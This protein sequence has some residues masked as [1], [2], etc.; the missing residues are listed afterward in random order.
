MRSFRLILVL[1]FVASSFAFV[2]QPVGV[3]QQLAIDT[4]G[5]ALEIAQAIAADPSTVVGA[6]FLELPPS[7]TPTAVATGFLAGFP[8]DGADYGILTS[9]DANLADDA[10]TSGSSG[11]ANGGNPVRGNTDYDVTVLRIDLDVP[12]GVNCL[13]GIEFRFLSDEYPE[14]VGTAFNDAFILEL[15]ATSWTTS[16]S[17][18]SAP[19]NFAFDPTGSV[20]SINAAGGTSMTAAAAEGT[21]Y[22][23]ATPVLTAATP[24]TPGMHS[25]YISIFDQGDQIYDSAVFLDNLR[26]GTVADVATE[27][28]PGAQVVD[29]QRPLPLLGAHGITGTRDNMEPNLRFAESVV[30]GLPGWRSADLQEVG[31]VWENGIKLFNNAVALAA[32]HDSGAV[33]VIAHSKG[34]LDARVAMSASPTIFEDLAMLATP[35]GG[36][37]LAD[38]LCRLRRLEID[39]VVAEMGPCDNAGDGLYNLQTGYIADVFNVIVKDSPQHDFWIAAGD[40]IGAAFTRE[41]RISCNA[42]ALLGHTCTDVDGP[43][44]LGDSDGENAVCVWSAFAQVAGFDPGGSHVAIKPV[45]EGLNHTDMRQDA[46][47]NTAVLAWMYGPFYPDNPWVIGDG[48]ACENMSRLDDDF[49]AATSAMVPVVFSSTQ[50]VNAV[51]NFGPVQLQHLMAVE[52]GP[53]GT[54]VVSVSDEDA[55]FGVVALGGP[56]DVSGLEVRDAAGGVVDPLGVQ[57]VDVFD[58]RGSLAALYP[59]VGSNAELTVTGDAGAVIGL[60]FAVVSEVSA[61]ADAVPQ[62]DGTVQLVV[63]VHGASPS[64]ANKLEVVAFVGNGPHGDPVALPLDRVSGDQLIYRASITPELGSYQPV[65]I[66]ISG[67]HTRLV[68]TGFIL[69]DGTGS[70]EALEYDALVDTDGDNYPDVLELGIRVSSDVAGLHTLSLQLK[71]GD[72]VAGNG[73]ATAQLAVGTNTMVVQIDLVEMAAVGLAGPYE[74]TDLVLTR[75]LEMAWVARADSLGL[76]S[77]LPLEALGSGILRISRPTAE[78]SDRDRDGRFD[79][80][81]WSWTTWAPQAGTYEFEAALFGPQG[82]QIGTVSLIEELTEGP[83]QLTFAFDGAVVGDHLAGRYGLVDLTGVLS[84]DRQ[85]FARAPAGISAIFDPARWIAGTPDISTLIGLWRD[86]FNKGE[87]FVNGLYR[88]QLNRLLRVERAIEAGNTTR[89]VR[90]LGRFIDHVTRHSGRL[91]TPEAA[92]QVSGYASVLKYDLVE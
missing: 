52:L 82:E 91:I 12:S 26:F 17:E 8:R 22:D 62:A 30:D 67:P 70:I 51:T 2:P 77:P 71:S 87:I 44:G 1:G 42:T 54:A 92:L 41:G 45:F 74:V 83:N 63:T 81:T 50:S 23:G 14:F 13:V 25:L 68:S 37:E 69:A 79:T 76:T 75:G 40:C 4:S 78:P 15:D 29:Q 85:V 64:V 5:S 57:A 89:V 55:G 3:A 90:E 6:E 53:D 20:I 80:L 47:P 36:S 21:T 32:A 73:P 28:R 35:N 60:G 48:D 43:F 18:I 88:S 10:N 46:C 72:V 7:G 86:A 34:G 38:T 19:D 66:E 49:Q 65:D 61:E 9:G 31:S 39:G 84:S 59:A 11:T 56:G 24:I 33:N 58:V 27:C 16:G